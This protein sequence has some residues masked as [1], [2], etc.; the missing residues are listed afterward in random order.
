MSLFY[1]VT[2]LAVSAVLLD[3]THQVSRECSSSLD[4]GTFHCRFTG[5]I[6]S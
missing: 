6:K 3:R 5:N 4:M 1:A 2:T